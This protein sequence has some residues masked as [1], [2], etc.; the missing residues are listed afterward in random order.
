[1]SSLTI[2]RLQAELKSFPSANS[3]FELVECTDILC[4]KVKV[5]GADETIYSGEEFFLQV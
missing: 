2:R 3:A 4:W 5:R 1:M